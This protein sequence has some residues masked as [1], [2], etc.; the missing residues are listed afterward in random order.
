M[1]VKFLVTSIIFTLALLPSVSKPANALGCVNVD[2][3]NQIKIT[4]SK[5]APGAQT[6]NVNQVIDP[7]CVGN[8]I[9]HK[10]NQ[11]H[12]GAEGADQTRNS[13]QYSG[14]S[15]NPAIPASVMGAGNVNFQSGTKTTIYN[16][17]L[18]PNFLHRR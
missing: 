9:V 10:T 12:V 14:G 5:D 16:P 18:D 15:G 2:V 3:S 6:N 4:G 11:V 17:A 8:T 13:N 7:S 1:Y